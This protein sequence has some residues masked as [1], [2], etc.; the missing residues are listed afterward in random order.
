M[1][2][3]SISKTAL[4]EALDT[5]ADGLTQH[6]AEKRLLIHGTND[7]LEQRR[8]TAL[9]M[10]LLQFKDIMILILFVAAAIAFLANDFKDAIIIL[11]II[12]LNAVAGFIQQYRA[13]KAIDA[14]KKMSVSEARVKRDKIVQQVSSSAIV[15]GDVVL[16]E[17]GER[18][19]A[20]LRI[21]EQHTLRIDESSLTGESVA[22]DKTSHELGDHQLPLADRRNMAYKNTL[23]TYGRGVGI[24]VATGMKTEVG[25]IAQMLQDAES[26]TPLQ[27]RLAIFSKNLSFA[28]LA[29]CAVI[30]GAGILRGEEPLRTLL[31]AISVAVAAVP[32]A[33]PSV[34]TIALAL[35]AKKMVRKQVLIRKLPA[36]ESLGSVTFICTDK[37]GTLTQNRMTVVNTWAPP[38][39]IKDEIYFVTNAADLL[40][41]AMNINH[42]AS[43]KEDG[44]MH[45]DPTETALARY[46]QQHLKNGA[47]GAGTL[48]RVYE[49][50]FD[51]DRKMMTTVHAMNG[52]YLVIT[53]GALESV[54]KLCPGADAETISEQAEAMAVQ[55][56]RVLAYSYKVIQ[57]STENIDVQPLE[58]DQFF[59]GLAGMLDP[60]REEV[61]KAVEE[62][63]TAGI[64]PVMI[65]GD[66]AGTARAIAEKLGILRSEHDQ[67][68][69]GARL[70]KMSDAELA[71][72]I[73]HIKVYA[74]VTAA[75]KLR[76][77]KA[78]QSAQQFVAMTGDGVNDSP[79]LKQ[80]NIGIAMGIT[81]TDISKEAAHMILLD[82][83]FASIV[84]AVKEG[85]RIFD[86]IRKFIRYILTGNSAEIWTIF[87]APLIGLPI[88][89]L[90]IH[91]LWINL[92][93]DGLPGIAL[94]SEPAEKNIMLRPPRQPDENIFANGLGY[95]VLWV[96][97]LM[98]GLCLGIQ[99]WALHNDNSKWQ[100]MV[101]TV[102]CL[103]QMMHVMGVR[104]ERTSVIRQGIFSNLPLAGAVLLTFILQL[105][106][107]YTPAL[108][109]I[110]STQPLTFSELALCIGVSAVVLLAVE[111]EKLARRK[112][113]AI[114]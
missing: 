111:I 47:P 104:S 69:T 85:R 83:N 101:F 108:Q 58:S 81:G 39:K 42:D 27:K 87:L 50:P 68:I 77:V 45:G 110:F 94:A 79:A 66:H 41:V 82:D 31:V 22:V 88:P 11:V 60:P 56:Q 109:A 13:E 9:Q 44:S 16:L 5:T 59:C 40:L 23:V 33:L 73:M 15:P 51:S 72:H 92:V 63:I 28:V 90:P 17:A 7:L 107:L 52:Q 3:Y 113:P 2:W 97:L 61:E 24:V 96:G 106:I 36:V 95:H 80:S 100:T 105:A 37:T 99:A 8:N 21:I 4:F 76:I 102:L 38:E 74:R 89:L 112:S 12:V 70:D 71:Q 64:V 93:T 26:Q 75:Q 25:A 98:G 19:P 57:N 29:I 34:I 18:V 1:K 62:C 86:N 20:D 49:L 32:E 65:T 48:E 54:L 10:F 53:K 114:T 91:I 6:E 84:K 78:L 14:L 30:Y 46:A 55:G 103:C 43:V 35:G 67:I